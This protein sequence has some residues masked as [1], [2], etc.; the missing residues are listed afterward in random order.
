MVIID[1]VVYPYTIYYWVLVDNIYYLLFVVWLCV[2]SFPM[3]DYLLFFFIIYF[4]YVMSVLVRII[5]Y[6]FII[7][8]LA[9]LFFTPLYKFLR[10]K[11]LQTLIYARVKP[12]IFAKKTIK[13]EK[14]QVFNFFKA[15]KTSYFDRYF[16][17]FVSW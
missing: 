7:F 17:Y 1:I 10:L 14:C 11:V 5:D 4:C 15:I 2:P 8:F 9:Y 13:N 12:D 3:S 16:S 6:F